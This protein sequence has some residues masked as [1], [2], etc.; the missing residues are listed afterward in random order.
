MNICFRGLILICWLW[1][2]VS[3]AAVYKQFEG[4]PG[5]LYSAKL[6]N[7]VVEYNST[8]TV[9]R[10]P[11]MYIFDGES[12]FLQ[13]HVD[14]RVSFIE[15]GSG[16]SA[17][18]A[19]IRLFSIGTVSEPGNKD[20]ALLD[21]LIEL[22]GTSSLTGLH[23]NHYL[24]E[25]ESGFCLGSGKKSVG[26]AARIGSKRYESKLTVVCSQNS[27]NI[28]NEAALDLFNIDINSINYMYPPVASQSLFLSN[29]YVQLNSILNQRKINVSRPWESEHLFSGGV[30][31]SGGEFGTGCV[32]GREGRV[33]V[34]GQKHSAPWEGGAIRLRFKFSLVPSSD[35][36]T[37]LKYGYKN[38]KVGLE[39]R[40][41]YDEISVFLG[42]GLV[43]G[44]FFNADLLPEEVNYFD[45]TLSKSNLKITLNEQ[46]YVRDLKESEYRP[47]YGGVLE[48][49]SNNTKLSRIV[50]G[51]GSLA[52]Q[53]LDQSVKWSCNNT[54]D[55][56]ARKTHFGSNY[57]AGTEDKVTVVDPI[58][59]GVEKG[60]GDLECLSK[61][62]R[63]C[64]FKLPRDEAIEGRGL[65]VNSQFSKKVKSKTKSA[66]IFHTLGGL[67]GKDVFKNREVIGKYSKLANILSF[68]AHVFERDKQYLKEFADRENLEYS[69][70]LH[71]AMR[72]TVPDSAEMLRKMFSYG[73]VNGVSRFSYWNVNSWFQSYKN[74]RR[75][76]RYTLQYGANDFYLTRRN[77]VV[78]RAGILSYPGRVGVVGSLSLVGIQQGMEDY[79]LLMGRCG[80]DTAVK[81]VLK[82]WE[83]SVSAIS[84]RRGMKE[85]DFDGFRKLCI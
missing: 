79:A 4:L 61:K 38:R 19:G 72:D 75:P 53:Q 5:V 49:D 85:L 31:D 50:W 69:L 32:S 21:P 62:D 67:Y 48:V 15:F 22:K 64:Y 12:E 13:F 63:G 66:N 52:E 26:V 25:I 45:L 44:R 60:I 29:Q 9:S 73:Y 80:T 24:L 82:Q 1:T 59:L 84:F 81:L 76:G 65:S 10:L 23:G 8:S 58:M 20:S 68:R 51:S 46:S 35:P 41:K 70:Y 42:D 11:T 18:V 2:T 33:Y 40:I 3:T 28:Q 78:L 17:P 55:V 43:F 27:I 16:N 7:S 77:P 37:V 6:V 34:P 74:S 14:S 47:A 54:D 39:V 57:I 83:S 30:F 36:E 56:R 71:D